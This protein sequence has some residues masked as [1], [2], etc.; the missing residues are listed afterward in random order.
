MI[1][2]F[3]QL[4][5]LTLLLGTH[6]IAQIDP[7]EEKINS[8]KTYQNKNI[9][10]KSYLHFEQSQNEIWY[11]VYVY[12]S[13]LL[14][15]TNLSNK[16]TISLFDSKDRIIDSQ[17]LR[18]ENGMSNGFFSLSEEDMSKVFYLAA[19]TEWQKNSGTPLTK[20]FVSKAK[21]SFST[22]GDAN[23]TYHLEHGALTNGL[24]QKLVVSS[25]RVLTNSQ[26][27]LING[28]GKVI[29]SQTGMGHIASFQIKPSN[30]NDSFSVRIEGCKNQ[31]ELEKPTEEGLIVEVKK[32]TDNNYLLE[33]TN[34]GIEI[35][36]NL[37]TGIIQS[38]GEILTRANLL[39]SNNK[40][41]AIISEEKL[42]GGI[43]QITLLN[44]NG[45]ALKS[46]LIFVDKSDDLKPNIILSKGGITL[47]LPSDFQMKENSY[48][49]VAIRKD[50]SQFEG[51]SADNVNQVVDD[52][53]NPELFEE[54]AFNQD[55]N[56]F[57]ITQDWNGI[58][59][60]EL[61]SESTRIQ[62]SILRAEINRINLE[63]IEYDEMVG[64]VRQLED[65]TVTVSR[66]SIERELYPGLQ[67]TGKG[68]VSID[69]ASNPYINDNQ[70]VL[71]ILQSR[72]AGVR[73]TGD[74]YGPE[75]ISINMRGVNSLNAGNQP[76]ILLDGVGELT[77]QDLALIRNS[78][79]GRLEIFRGPSTSR[80]GA[81]G[82]AGVI[83]LF[84]RVT[85][86]ATVDEYVEAMNFNQAQ[87]TLTQT[88]YKIKGE[89]SES[90]LFIWEFGLKV[91]TDNAIQIPLSKELKAAG[92]FYVRIESFNGN[93]Q[94]QSAIIPVDLN[95]MQSAKDSQ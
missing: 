79:I 33:I 35:P 1:R 72:V 91:K 12:N 22:C 81:R 34:V 28:D 13:S 58:D 46:K 43:S 24:E 89:K 29:D 25:N 80:F 83:A 53:S 64:N 26:I 40:A 51:Y 50:R 48:I 3:I 31:L 69:I 84:S 19:Q 4:F 9:A 23:L 66:E 62:D 95:N 73:V 27:E 77:P 92:S 49:S 11:S 75:G 59:W 41:R 7:L 14:S 8:F 68:D 39:L 54:S 90:D 65:V 60:N 88:K 10:E 82:G 17:T 5:T 44:V 32:F 70:S 20:Y 15:P 2:R 38:N 71:D 78:E 74:V 57:L 30:L 61:T 45:E 93:G 47:Q 21:R 52:I 18:I 6:L 94:S 37:L 86:K 42:K 85:S 67:L 56:N 55:L 87:A 63:N 76:L 16:T 36:K